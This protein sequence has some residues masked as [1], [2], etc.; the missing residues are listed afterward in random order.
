MT[1]YLFDMEHI[2]TI[3]ETEIKKQDNPINTG[4]KFLDETIGGFYPG[5]MTTVCGSEDCGKTAFV[6]TQLN[7]IAVDQHIPTLFVLNNMTERNFLSSMIAYYCN[8]ETNNVH[9]IFD[10]EL[11]QEAVK[12]Y[13][14]MLSDTPLYVVNAEWFEDNAFFEMLE[15]LI[16]EKD[17]KIAF[18]DEVVHYEIL[19][20][21][22]SM[23]YLKTLSMKLN[24]PVVS[25]CCIW[26]YREGLDGVVPALPDLSKYCELHGHDVVISFIKYEQYHVYQDEHGHDL[27]DTIGVEI[28]KHKGRIEN[29]KHFLPLGCLY[30]RNYAQQQKASLEVIKQ[31]NF[32]KVDTLIKK[33]DLEIDEQ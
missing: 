16:V 29:R 28:L 24:I 13:L 18:F 15:K 30:L 4:F 6:I 10:T 19:A 22:G 7:R 3:I 31:S 17:I 20:E 33:F 26:N 5:E 12:A 27:H 25:T 23:S 32:Y 2:S 11:Q 8:I 1:I 9:S 21:S 14:K